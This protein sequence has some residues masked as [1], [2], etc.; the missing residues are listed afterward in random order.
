MN[1]YTSF[2]AFFKRK[3]RPECRKIGN[4]LFISPC[5][6]LLTV[7]HIDEGSIFHIKHTNYSL[8]SLLQSEKLAEEFSNGTALIFM[9]QRV[10]CRNHC[11]IFYYVETSAK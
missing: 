9:E 5:D 10:S 7:S 6:G 4:G 11:I 1:G 3:I 2:N 8:S